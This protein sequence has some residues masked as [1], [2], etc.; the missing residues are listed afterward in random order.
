MSKL[1]LIGGGTAVALYLIY[2]RKESFFDKENKDFRDG[3]TAGFFTPGPFTI[4]GIAG[5]IAWKI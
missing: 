2:Q 5:I 4:L 3:F 1:L